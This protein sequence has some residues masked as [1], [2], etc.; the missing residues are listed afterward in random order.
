MVRLEGEEPAEEENEK[1]ARCSISYVSH[2][3]DVFRL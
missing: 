1:W 3:G 2:C